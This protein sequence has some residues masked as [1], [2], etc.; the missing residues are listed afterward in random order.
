MSKLHYRFS[1]VGLFV[2]ANKVSETADNVRDFET[3]KAEGI[4]F[5]TAEIKA[6]EAE[7]IRLT[8]QLAE[9]EALEEDGV[10]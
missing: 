3:A 5:L 7:V 1:K 10:K 6:T 8:K 9:L 4:K 2:R